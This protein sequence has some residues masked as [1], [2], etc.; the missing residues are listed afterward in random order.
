MDGSRRS[1]TVV[2]KRRGGPVRKV[3]RHFPYGE[4]TTRPFFLFLIVHHLREWDHTHVR[5]L[6]WH[7]TETNSRTEDYSKV[8]NQPDICYMELLNSKQHNG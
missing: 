2:V 5:Y 6:C 1:S 8:I 3:Q 7:N 4:T